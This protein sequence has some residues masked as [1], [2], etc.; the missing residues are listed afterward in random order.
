MKVAPFS[1][2]A[3]RIVTY[4]SADFSRDL[5]KFLRGRSLDLDDPLIAKVIPYCVVVENQSDHGLSGLVAIYDFETPRGNRAHV[6]I[7]LLNQNSNHPEQNFA[8]GDV[9]LIAPVPMLATSIQR[10]GGPQSWPSSDRSFIEDEVAEFVKNQNI[11]LSIDSIIDENARLVG[12]D[13]AQTLLRLN[14][15]SDAEQQLINQVAATLS[16]VGASAAISELKAVAS[17]DPGDPE[18]ASKFLYQRAQIQLARLL[19]GASNGSVGLPDVLKRFGSMQR[20]HVTRKV[21]LK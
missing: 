12:P 4:P 16:S 6:S 20:L 2:G 19:L 3:V 10:L 5:N 21:E 11:S 17:G 14:A 1:E 15:K 13:R 7:F 8:V 18:I 9:S